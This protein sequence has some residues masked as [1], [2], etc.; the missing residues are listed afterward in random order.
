MHHQSAPQTWRTSLSENLFLWFMTGERCSGSPSVNGK[1]L[2]I[3]LP[4]MI[5]LFISGLSEAISASLILFF[6]GITVT[7]SKALHLFPRPSD[8]VQLS[9][10]A[11]CEEH[12]PKQTHHRGC[13][14]L[15]HRRPR[16]QA[17]T[18]CRLRPE[19]K[20]L[21]WTS[22]YRPSPWDYLLINKKFLEPAKVSYFSYL[23]PNI[24]KTTN[25]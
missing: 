6:V 18:L 17:G 24:F 5:F 15:L 11:A 1:Q 14:P 12:F 3:A 23:N 21:G 10:I 25:F 9:A 4:R 2:V 8:L 19:F 16:S 22:Q 7:K 20:P 13:W